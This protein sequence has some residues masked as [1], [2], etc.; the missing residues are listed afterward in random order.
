MPND[1][2][3]PFA[4]RSEDLEY[5]RAG[6]RALLARLYRPVGAGVG[7]G[8]F[9]A[10]V[11]VHGGAWVNADRLQ[12]QP[13]AEALAASGIVVLSL[14]FR[15]PP[16]A[17]YP[18]SLQDINYGI[19]WLKAHA[20]EYGTEAHRV[21]GFGTSSGGHQIL[22]AALRPHDPR[23]A[24]LP[25]V[26]APAIDAG[27]AFV[28]SGWG[29][30]DP[31]ARYALARTRG[32]A[33]MVDNHD[34]FWGSEAAMADGSPPHILAR[35]ETVALPPALIFQ[36]TADEWVPAAIAENLAAAWRRAGG[37]VELGLYE[38]E[39]HTFMREKPDAP[40]SLVAMARLKAFIHRHGG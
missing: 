11:E 27:L 26:E 1:S 30:L 5:R 32:N 40:H 34:R 14:D 37:A 15:M 38:G 21:G 39:G 31:V 20:T 4:V 9:P 13:V 36:G 17:G 6:D 33:G 16:E 29:V 8:P 19:R 7:P 18:A 22:L 28:I 3:A 25:L 12:N 2:E 24:A 35:G 23:Y 10:V